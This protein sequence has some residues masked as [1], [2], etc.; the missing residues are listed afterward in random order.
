MVSKIFAGLKD[1][2]QVILFDENSE[3]YGEVVKLFEYNIENIKPIS[4]VDNMRSI[5][6]DDE[7][8]FI[9]ISDDD[10]NNF[11]SNIKI[12]TNSVDHNLAKENDY[13]NIEV[14]YL[15]NDSAKTVLL[16]KIYPV[17][18]IGGGKKYLICGEKA[19]SYKEESNKINLSLKVHVYY[20]INKKTFY[21]EN[22]KHLIDIFKNLRNTDKNSCASFFG[23]RT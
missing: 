18:R 23:E 22:F 9:E 10:E 1:G 6:S 5:L 17:Q 13:P 20:D 16:K 11:F 4:F 7:I 8:F 3:D 14:I 2:N 15:V 19:P 21:F 12:N